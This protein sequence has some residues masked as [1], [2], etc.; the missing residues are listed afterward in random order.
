VPFAQTWSEEL[1][2][3]WLELE[4]YLVAIEIPTP[5]LKGK[6]GRRAPDVVG[7][8]I[9]RN[10]MEIV[11]AE[12]GNWP[13]GEEQIRQLVRRKF[14]E[15]VVNVVKEYF[16]KRLD[17]KGEINYKKLLVATW[18]SKKREDQIAKMMEQ[19]PE[20]EYLHL[21]EILTRKIPMALE[22]YKKGKAITPLTPLHL[23]HLL[24]NLQQ[25]LFENTKTYRKL[26]RVTKKKDVT[27]MELIRTVIIP[28][29]IKEKKE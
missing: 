4:G 11:Q 13:I 24:D 1:V 6:G 21:K 26:E 2:A 14:D 28:E 7:A 16:Q 20:L 19:E 25:S 23:V 17:F 29:W 8:R 15:K 12:V 10:K 5:S 18:L 9:K 3:E 22:N 27:I